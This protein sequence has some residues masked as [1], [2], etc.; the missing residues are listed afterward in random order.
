MFDVS[1][2]TSNQD[3]FLTNLAYRRQVSDKFRIGLEAQFSSP[4]YRF[5][6]AK[7]ITEGYASTISIPLTLR[8]YEREKIRLD[9]YTKAGL[10]FQ[11]VLDPDNNDKR[12]SLL[13]STAFLF[14]PG[15]LVTVKLNE[16]LNFQSGI[17]FPALFQLSPSF[18][19]ENVYPGLLHLGINHQSSA[20]RTVFAKALFG[21]ATGGN[22]DTQK[23]GWSLQA[24]VR[25]NLGKRPGAS[26]VEPSF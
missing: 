18:I 14:E 8:L 15:L 3:N 26:F 6:N 21:G 12:D 9:L 7:P 20:R 25:F 10:R 1:V 19:F 23:F 2:G 13:T 5:I 17:T 16:K 11:G 4:R 22:G 24:G